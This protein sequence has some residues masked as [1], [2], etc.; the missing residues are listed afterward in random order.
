MLQVKGLTKKYRNKQAL[1]PLSFT[2]EKGVYALLG[3]NGAGKSTMMN[4]I[5]DNLTA[6]SGMVFWKGEPI[7]ALGKDYRRILGFA[8]QQQGLY[9]EFTARYFLSY[10]S[11][12][13]EIPKKNIPAEVE[14]VARLVNL[15][16]NLDQQLGSFSGGMKQRVLIA[17]ALIG[18]P[19]LIILDEPTAGL[20]PKE[21]V[22]IRELC[23]MLAKDRILLIATHVVSDIES[24]A[25]EVL[26]LKKGNLLAKET[27][28]TLINSYCPDGDLEDVYM[29]L[30]G[31]GD[32]SCFLGLN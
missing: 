25:R 19:E 11:A 31:S 23:R 6:D 4:I 22:R 15:Q 9:E 16:E 21:R 1:N 20:D 10:L 26:L 28:A 13:K 30:F 7:G 17:Q 14:R 18:S 32:E 27:V 5:T 29:H 24:I 3:P 12:L 8:P 2:L